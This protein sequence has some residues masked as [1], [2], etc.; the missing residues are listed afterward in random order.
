MYHVGV[1]TEGFLIGADIGL[2]KSLASLW[3][4]VGFSVAA[5]VAVQTIRYAVQFRSNSELK[6]VRKCLILSGVAMVLIFGVGGISMLPIGSSA[7]SEE[8]LI[9][10]AG[11][12]F[13]TAPLRIIGW[14]LALLSLLKC[15]AWRVFIAT[16]VVLLGGISLLVIIFA[17]VVLGAMVGFGGFVMLLN[18]VI[19]GAL[20]LWVLSWLQ[21]AFG[22]RL[23]QKQSTPPTGGNNATNHGNPGKRPEHKPEPPPPSETPMHPELSDTPSIPPHKPESEEYHREKKERDIVTALVLQGDIG[24]VEFA[25]TVTSIAVGRETYSL[26]HSQGSRADA[27]QFI[28]RAREDGSVWRLIP[29]NNPV[30]TVQ[31]NGA[32]LNG[33][34]VL[35]AGDKISLLAAGE[36]DYAKAFAEVLVLNRKLVRTKRN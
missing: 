21:L 17:S 7:G 2:A 13:L 14:I 30:T 1:M 27:R 29:V 19:A 36:T 11:K 9:A 8:A 23:A 15:K 34:I 3:S 22:N 31:V 10:Q 16:N 28:L 18:L 26:I 5:F 24:R 6:E 4:V 33:M 25:P 12:A 32:P 20:A 35:H